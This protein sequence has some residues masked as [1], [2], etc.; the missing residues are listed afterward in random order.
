MRAM[1]LAA[2][3][4]KRMQPLTADLPKPLLRVGDKTLIEHQIE[5]LVAG[6]VTGVVINHFYLGGMIEELLGNGSKY[7]TSISY[8]K[9]AI[10]LESAGGIIKALPKLK[11][12]CFVVVNAD[13]WTDFNFSR[14]EPVDGIDRLA[15]LVL[16]E[17]ADHNPRGDFNIDDQNRVR[18]DHSARD[19]RLTFSGISVMHKNLFSGY[20]I[21]PKSMVPL[22]QEAMLEDRVSG[23]V[24]EGLWMDIGTPERLQEVNALVEAEGG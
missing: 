13:I 12:D 1:I 8:S 18:E 22:L 17:N 9:E 24:Y 6:G 7:G 23:E 11:D 4:G 21:Q 15:H 3:L 2:G 10:R 14:L 19:Q 16:V 5:R 20:P